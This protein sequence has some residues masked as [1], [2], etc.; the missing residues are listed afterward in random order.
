MPQPRHPGA[1][2]FWGVTPIIVLP[3]LAD[4]KTAIFPFHKNSLEPSRHCSP[5]SV[6]MSSRAACNP[7]SRAF[8]PLSLS[9]AIFKLK[10]KQL[11]CP[12]LKNC[13]KIGY[14]GK[15]L[16]FRRG[17]GRIL[18]MQKA[19]VIAKQPPM[20]PADEAAA[21]SSIGFGRRGD[22]GESHAVRGANGAE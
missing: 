7:N 12:N 20:P 3:G 13:E 22:G 18:L 1:P 16:T 10:H 17:G 5:P 8:R 19:K 11:S 6:R 15:N 4:F 9:C 14:A 2:A 21:G